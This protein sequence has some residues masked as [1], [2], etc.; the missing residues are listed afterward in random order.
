MAQKGASSSTQALF[1]VAD[2]S[3]EGVGSLA[4]TRLPIAVLLGTEGPSEHE[5]FAGSPR[6]RK[7]RADFHYFS[8]RLI[9]RNV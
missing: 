2:S 8:G 1:F 4:D 9:P 5:H 3:D 7:S 6:V